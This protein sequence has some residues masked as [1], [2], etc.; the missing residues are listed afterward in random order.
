MTK[1]LILFVASLAVILGL[2]TSGSSFAWFV[3][4]NYK[5]QSITVSLVSNILTANLSDLKAPDNTIIIQGDNLVSLDGQSA[6][7]QLENQSTTETQLR[8]KV[9]YTSYSSGKGEQVVYSDSEDD[10]ITVKFADG[11]WAKNINVAGI[12]YFYY[13]GGGYYEESVD[14]LG[15]VPSI[16]PEVSKIPA[17]SEISYNNDVPYSYSGQS[18]NVKVTFEY[19]QAENITWT[20]IDSYEVT[21]LG[22]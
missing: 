22:E 14:N 7:L 21:G 13:M 11:S 10:D 17:I 12:C 20:E 19:K 4:S 18:V 6:M 5:N 16:S 1:R 2:M 15:S 8:L 9:E 3:S